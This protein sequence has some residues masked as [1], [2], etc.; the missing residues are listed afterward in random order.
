MNMKRPRK[1]KGKVR[2]SGKECDQMGAES[3][4][5]CH[6]S[7]PMSFH[8]PLHPS[9]PNTMSSSIF[10]LELFQALQNHS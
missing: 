4:H 3:F 5:L 7:V 2:K 1:K 6:T 8:P 10:F 9:S